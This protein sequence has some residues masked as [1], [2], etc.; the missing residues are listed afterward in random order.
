MR[1]FRFLPLLVAAACS[2]APTDDPS[3]ASHDDDGNEYEEFT[4][5]SK[6]DGATKLGG[7]IHFS[8]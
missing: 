5:D 6:A 3:A 7:P 8:S 2:A 1:H 4:P